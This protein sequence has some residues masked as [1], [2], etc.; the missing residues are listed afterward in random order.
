[1]GLRLLLISI[2]FYHSSIRKMEMKNLAKLLALLLLSVIPC[3]AQS[4]TVSGTITDSGSQAWANG[5][6]AISF[7]PP[8]GPQ[9]KPFVWSGGA[10]NPLLI[11]SGSLSNTGTY[12]VSIPSNT[13]IVPPNTQWSFQF[14]PQATPTT[15]YTTT[16]VVSGTTQTLSPT[17]P[18]VQVNIGPTNSLA[19][20]DSEVVGA[21]VGSIYYNLTNSVSRICTVVMAGACSTWANLGGGGSGTVTSV[22]IAGTAN[23]IAV[24]GGCA[25]TT[26]GTC[27]LSLPS[28]LVLP[29]GSTA[30]TQTAGDNTTKVA[31]DAF[32]L[33]NA[34]GGSGG[35]VINV[36]LAPYS[37]VPDG[38]TNNST[39]IAAAFTAAN[40]ITVGFPTVY[41]PCVTGKG[42]Q[43]N[44]TDGGTT[45]PIHATIPMNIVG[46]HGVVL[47]DTGTAHMIDYTTPTNPL[48]YKEQT[49]VHGLRFI[50]ASCTAGVFID[51]STT[52]SESGKVFDDT[53]YDLPSSSI[54]IGGSGSIYNWI[55][56]VNYYVCDL[57]NCGTFIN[58]GPGSA[59][60]QQVAVEHNVAFCAGSGGDISTC[61]S[62]G[63]AVVVSGSGSMVTDNYFVMM[64]IQVIA[65]GLDSHI[66]GNNVECINAP[67]IQ[68]AGS[69]SGLTIDNNLANLH[70]VSGQPFIGFTSTSY[71]MSNSAVE[72][73][74]IFNIVGAGLIT[75]NN[76]TGQTGNQAFGNTCNNLA[77]G[78]GGTYFH[79]TPVS[80]ITFEPWLFLDQENF[81]D[82]FDGGSLATTWFD[83]AGLSVSGGVLVCSGGNCAGFNGVDLTANQTVTVKVSTVPTGTQ[84][85]G[86]MGRETKASGG[87]Y[88]Y[89][90]CTWAAGGG[91]LT[92]S[93][94]VSNSGTTLAS[95]S[96]ATLNVGDS[97][98][99]SSIGHF[100]T[101]S[102][103]HN[104]A[105]SFQVSAV[106]SSVAVGYPGLFV[107]STAAAS[108]FT[109]Q[110]AP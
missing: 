43:Y 77:C 59:T 13:A 19:Y 16:V 101:C 96:G 10:F 104:G 105:V 75:E 34:G 89:M 71:T 36:S 84:I 35:P 11:I 12:S 70:S 78:S 29:N 7:V 86:P 1:V 68:I 9:T 6:Y 50:C 73:N 28:T 92:L 61:T 5:S 4:T 55:F 106:D 20:S 87:L 109:A 14:C 18:A 88:T 46:D 53:F 45:S 38:S 110:G 93:K 3:S 23:E 56:D 51:G 48:E 102:T 76:L 62:S 31:T 58:L 8:P 39:A 57:G 49:E 98:Q 94:T 37:A 80:T 69:V 26:T 32:V 100:H 64:P 47:D 95:S 82:T 40:A 83:D 44:Y 54:A 72:N 17:P 66:T 67:C 15:C 33:A 60:T 81:A 24:T 63:P 30:T 90:Q 52:P 74:R 21:G 99:L 85:I 65:G 103:I 27:T 41:F 91:G 2:L 97:V 79:Q 42:C 108:A 25:I 22:T 107:G